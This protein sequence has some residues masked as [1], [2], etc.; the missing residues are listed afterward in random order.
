VSDFDRLK[1]LRFEFCWVILFTAQEFSLFGW[2]FKR[3]GN[4]LSFTNFPL[5]EL[6]S[7]LSKGRVKLSEL[8]SIPFDSLSKLSDLLTNVSEVLATLSVPLPMHMQLSIANSSCSL[9]NLSM[10][11]FSAFSK[12]FRLFSNILSSNLFFR[13]NTS[14][15]ALFNGAT[16]FSR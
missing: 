16:G 5:A 10:T 7:V 14:G 8:L 12:N 6:F 2:F 15:K 13:R 9:A 1:W 11:F 4:T 3:F